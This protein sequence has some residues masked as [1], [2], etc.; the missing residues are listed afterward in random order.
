MSLR[1]GNGVINLTDVVSAQGALSH[2]TSP[3]SMSSQISASSMPFNSIGIRLSPDEVISQGA[4]SIRLPFSS[5][6]RYQRRQ[7]L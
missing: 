5:R 2:S 1:L 6:H 7:C 3:S 4:L